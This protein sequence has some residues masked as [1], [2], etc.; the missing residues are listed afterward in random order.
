MLLVQDR[1]EEDRRT[2][3][4]AAAESEARRPDAVF[5]A[6]L[7]GLRRPFHGEDD[8]ESY[9]KAGKPEVNSN[10]N[11]N[12]FS[13]DD[14]RSGHPVSRA[15]GAHEIRCPMLN[16]ISLA[17]VNPATCVSRDQ[18][19]STVC[20]FECPRGYEMKKS[21]LRTLSLTCGLDG[22]W[23]GKPE[24]CDD[25][26]A[27]E[28]T[29]PQDM[30]VNNEPQMSYAEVTWDEPIIKDNS[31]G[32]DPNAKI[33][34]TKSHTSPK[35]FEIG[36]NQVVTYSVKDGANLTASCNFRVTVQGG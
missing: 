14:V 5:C 13:V 16:S 18:R 11:N 36:K 26:E 10:N 21:K 22:Q 32:N 23:N 24:T 8:K 29:C 2:S 7:R 9:C 12:L 34:I 30:T 33:E 27:P 4:G 6:L 19:F 3:D 17:Q 28:I 31:Q 25:V 1:A 20:R 15:R 35:K